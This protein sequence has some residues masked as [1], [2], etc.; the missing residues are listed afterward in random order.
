MTDQ[1][2]KRK[3]GRPKKAKTGARA[4]FYL[5]YNALAILDQLGNGEKSEYVAQAIIEKYMRD[6]G[7]P[8]QA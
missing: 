8:K 1:Q 4:N 3:Q 7:K 6:A 2:V 5:P